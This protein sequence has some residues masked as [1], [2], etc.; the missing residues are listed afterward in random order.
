MGD[1]GVQA[2]GAD[3][4]VRFEQAWQAAIG[5]DS[6]HPS[7]VISDQILDPDAV[8]DLRTTCHSGID[9][10]T[11]QY[12]ATRR[13]QRADAVARLD[14]NGNVL[15]GVSSAAHSSA[16]IAR[17]RRASVRAWTACRC[18]R[19]LCRRAARERQL[20]PAGKRPPHLRT[21]PRRPRHQIS[22]SRPSSS[23]TAKT[24]AS[25]EDLD[26]LGEGV[27]ERQNATRGGDMMA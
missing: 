3:D 27:E 10:R 12:P 20:A 5:D 13:V 6:S 8:L 11:I 19:T 17:R 26:R 22:S 4:R 18:R 1:R 14:G 9:Q 23:A 15:T 24:A 16:A 25:L 2:V 7:M 21:V